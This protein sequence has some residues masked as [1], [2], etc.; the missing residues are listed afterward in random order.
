MM[1]KEEP[2]NYEFLAKSLDELTARFIRETGIIPTEV[3]IISLK[4]WVRNKIR[5]FRE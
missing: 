2:E 1:K 4:D 3:S 5:T